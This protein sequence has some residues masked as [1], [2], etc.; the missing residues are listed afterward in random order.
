VIANKWL[1]IIGPSKVITYTATNMWSKDDL[2]QCFKILDT[3]L[4]IFTWGFFL[5]LIKI[6]KLVNVDIKEKNIAIHNQWRG[7]KRTLILNWSRWHFDLLNSY[8]VKTL[9]LTTLFSRFFYKPSNLPKAICDTVM[10]TLCTYN[11]YLHSICTHAFVTL[12]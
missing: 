1:V 3:L 4:A 5:L 9:R 2:I 11:F 7:H 6:E 12:V 10:L 8:K